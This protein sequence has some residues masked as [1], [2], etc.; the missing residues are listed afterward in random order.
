[1]GRGRKVGSKRNN[2][3]RVRSKDRSSDES[4]EDYNIGEEGERDESDEYCS[5]NGDES[6]E[7][8]GD[9]EE[10][11][12]EEEEDY[13]EEEEEEIK[14]KRVAKPK[15]RKSFSRR[16][17][18]GAKKPRTKQSFSYKQGDDDDYEDDDDDEEFAPDESDCVDDEDD[19]LLLKENKKVGRPHLWEKVTARGQKTKNNSR[20]LKKP[21]TKKP[22]KKRRLARKTSSGNYVELAV[23]SVIVEEKS[24]KI[25]GQ[26]RRRF[27][28]DSDSDFVSSGSS[29]YEYTISEEEREQVREAS[30]FSKGLTTS[31]RSSSSSKRLQEE[32]EAPSKRRK[33]PDRKGKE[34]AKESKTEIGKQV[35]G[36]CLSEQGKRTVRGTLNCCTHYFCFTCIIEWSKVESR[37]PL[38]KQRFVTISKPAKSNMGFDLRTVVLQVPERDQVYQPS[39]EELRGYLDPYES[40]MCTECHQGGDDA[41]MLLCDICDSPAHTYCVGLGREVPEG[42]WYCEGCR[43]TAF[44]SSNPEGLN[45]TSDQRASNNFSGIS[46]PVHNVGEGIDLNSMYVPETPL[47]QESG[48][49]VG[50][51]VVA[52][53]A[54]ISWAS[55]VMERRRIQRQIH[56]LL[57]NRVSHSSGRSTGVP[58]RSSGIRLFGSQIGQG[59]ELPSELAVTP[60]RVVPNFAFSEERLQDNATALVRSGDLFSSR[61]SNSRGGQDPTSTSGG[62]TLQ[63]GL[64]GISMAFNSRVPYEPLHPCSSS[65]SSR[66]SLAPDTNASPYA[67]REVSHF[68]VEK[69]QVQQMVRGHLKS[70]SRDVELGYGAFKD[71]ARSSTHTILAACG[72]EHRESEAYPV[73]APPIC[74]H[75]DNIAGGPKSLMKACC[76][77]CFDVFVKDIVRK[78]INTRVSPLETRD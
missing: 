23:K 62:G 68:N 22:R 46:S 43:P 44:G 76:S 51:N 75:V 56:H 6:E 21:I 72:L 33:R 19:L 50:D 54:S 53:P 7:D 71:V 38:C 41:L 30:K 77:S 4:D 39:E 60:E 25:S 65:S 16:K 28:V 66:T 67:C 35:C 37:C 3:T 64:A 13:E 40:V 63:S 42:N 24:K 18:S 26:R 1:M 29:D 27:M 70:L 14:V 49:L 52:S 78:M 8:L 10:E 34:K 2:G 48:R 11:E 31:L 47:T 9:Y 32:E 20:V 69:R 61:P 55:T 58:A 12:E 45:S 17:V 5:L 15:P 57:S 36:I 59:R 73:Q 74:N